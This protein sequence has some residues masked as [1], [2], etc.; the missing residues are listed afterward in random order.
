MADLK[1]L[2]EEWPVIS[3]RLDEALSL[4]PDQRDTWLEGLTE[5]SSVKEKLRLF[6][7]D[8]DGVET[9]DFLETLPRLTLGF[10]GALGGGATHDAAPGALIGPYRLIRELGLG[11]MGSV[12]LGERIDGGL[13]RQVALKLPRMSWS[14]GLAER[15][16]R[17]RDI[18][19]SLDHPNIARIYDAGLDDHGRPYLALEYVEGEPMDAYCRHHALSVSARL[20]LLLQVAH[21]VAHAHARLVVHRD[22]K[23][24]NILVNAEGQVRLLDF[25]IAK[26]MEGELTQ[27]TKLTQQSGRALTLD[28]ASPEQIRGEPIGTASDVYR[29]GVVAY[30]L[31]TESKPYQ[32]KRQSPA[33]LEEAIA[34]IDVRPASAAASSPENRRALAGDLDAILNKALKKNTAERYPTIDAFAQDIERHLDNLPVL[35]QADTL[36]YRLGKFFSRNKLSVASGLAVSIALVAGLSVALWQARVATAQAERAEKVKDFALSIFED[37]DTDSGA[38]AKTTAADLLVSA[39]KRV[40]DG[41]SSR[42]EVAVE[43][44]TAIGYGMIG[45]GLTADA[46]SLLREAVALSTQALG[47]QHPLTAAAQAVFGESLVGLGQ[48]KDAI[49]VLLPCVESSRR[50][51]DQ[52]TLDACLRSLSTAYLSEG[53]VDLAID[54]AQQALATLTAPQGSGKPLGLVDK[55]DTYRLLAYAL[56]FANRPGAVD[57][58]RQSL[59][60][61]R[62]LSGQQITQP[63][64]STRAMLGEALVRDGRVEEGLRELDTLI[65]DAIALLGPKHPQ[66]ASMARQVGS[67]RQDAG[68]IT[69]AIEA[70]RRTVEI[71]DANDEKGR[72]FNRGVY[73]LHLAGAYAAARQP[74]AAVQVLDEAIGML[75]I[76]AGPDNPMTFRAIATRAMQLGEAG[77]LRESE[78][79]FAALDPAK[80]V[81][82]LLASYQLQL[83]R[84]RNLQGRYAEANSLVDTAAPTMLKLSGKGLHARILTLQGSFRLDAGDARSA[85]ELLQ[86]AIALYSQVELRKSP[87]HAIAL[88]ALGRA[89]LQSGDAKSATQSL[90]VADGFWQ[91]FDA[92]NRYAGLAKLYLAE[93]LA[94]QGEKVAATDA[95]RSANAILVKDGIP[96][97]RVRL[98]SVR[99]AVGSR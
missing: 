36:A 72:E 3:R 59:A 89:Q 54:A 4:E 48:H 9:N 80:A 96:T 10:D 85:L 91:N 61:A 87:D 32:L 43:L 57:A 31:L 17:E 51:N 77:R 69:G 81:G 65:P 24:A 83:A 70:L 52:R 92:K 79:A 7:A 55:R 49:K 38:G 20:R 50:I 35:A 46:S 23:P 86:K 34:S 2:A 56:H 76:G 68:D 66:A 71:D 63:I 47:P 37:A 8:I 16:I 82:P 75:K 45:Q 74:E 90:L 1:Y 98:A 26:L 13:K 44:M 14:P 94:S 67:A 28:Y 12:W 53:Q 25:G 15:M 64:L 93:S 29:L 99:S 73:R 21:A 84:L 60:F 18:L 30:E 22:L 62:E 27:E 6:L 39:R 95:W 42:P 40:K 41:L 78:A 58:A 88:V 33:A 19:A 11:G 5:P 97:D